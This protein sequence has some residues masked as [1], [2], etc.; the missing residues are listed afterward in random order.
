MFEVLIHHT[1]CENGS[2][3]GYQIQMGTQDS[4]ILR[5][6][7]VDF[8]GFSYYMSNAVQYGSISSGN[9]LDGFSNSVPNLHLIQSDWGWQIDPVGLRYNLNLLYERY[10]IPLFVVENG[11]GAVDKS[12]EKGE[13]YD[14][15]RI[16]YLKSHIKQLKKAVINDGVPVI[17]YTVWGGIDMV[18]FTTGEME[19]RYGMIYVDRDNAGNGTLVRKRKA[20][21]DWYRNVIAS[22][23]DEL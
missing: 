20:S 16:E 12:N 15:Y 18:S 22:N 2:K 6:G 4:E 21:F 14:T 11:F 1:R 10:Q 17:E 9:D 5:K 13:I 7:T 23:G 3:R 19:K 8:L